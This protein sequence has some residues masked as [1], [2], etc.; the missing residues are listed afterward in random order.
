MAKQTDRPSDSARGGSPGEHKFRY[1]LPPGNDFKFVQKM[2]LWGTIS[3]LLCI[4]SI[5]SLFVNKAVRGDY[6]NWTIDF[7]GGTE[8][9][10]SFVDKADPT[11]HVQVDAGKV[12]SA[13]EQGVGAAVD[14][15]DYGWTNDE[16]KQVDGM[17]IR[18][19]AFG[20]LRPD[21]ER[22]ATEKLQAAFAEKGL[23]KIR[24]SGD[25]VEI[26]SGQQLDEAVVKATLAEVGLELKPLEKQQA[27]LNATANEDTGEFDAAF[28]VYGLDR[29]YET[30]LERALGDVDVQVVQSHGVGAKAGDKLRDDGIK[31]IFYAMLLIVLYL[32]FRF[33]IRYAPGAILATLHDAIMVIGVLSVTWSEISLTSVA[34][35]LTVVGFSV[36]DTVVI[37]DR[38]RENLARLKDKKI[39][40]IVDISLNEV[41]IRSLLTSLTLFLVTLMMNLFG[42]GLVRDF[43]F[44][45]NA[46]IIVGAYSSLFLAPPVFIWIHR[47]YYMGPPARARKVASSAA[48]TAE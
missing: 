16:G 17:T 37:F 47:R 4:A 38:I 32:A 23:Q 41:L 27:V 40:R 25:R 2:R 28:S 7:K 30:T 44:T 9:V 34:A 48:A 5:A 1:L 6:M 46:G 45:M 13:L 39:E 10:V 21:T 29:Q 26:R 33:D 15:S 43:A 14:V 8:I 24:W 42:T 18:T 22:A 20:A 12:R 35:L 11:R 3:L 19:P 36:N 31:S